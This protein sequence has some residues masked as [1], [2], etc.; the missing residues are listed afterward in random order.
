MSTR[1]RKSSLARDTRI[2]P[3]SDEARLVWILLAAGSSTRFGGSRSKLLERLGSERVIDMTIR[4][5]RAA[6][7]GAAIILVS[8][9][10]MR[11]AV[12]LPDQSWIAGGARRH[13]GLQFEPG[14][15]GG[16]PV[17]Q[18]LDGSSDRLDALAIARIGHAFAATRH[19]AVTEFRD[20]DQGLGLGAA[21]DRKGTGNRPPFGGHFKS[22][23]RDWRQIGLTLCAALSA[24]A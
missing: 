22:Y 21:A 4:S 17:A 23:V 10:E 9:P 2:D 16:E 14:Q 3:C 6:V 19:M 1:N 11:D 15:A 13:R 20:H 7:P 12:G 5:L 18:R 8:S 24:A